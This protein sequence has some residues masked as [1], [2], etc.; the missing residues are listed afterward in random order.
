MYKDQALTIKSKSDI[1][2][3]RSRVRNLAREQGFNTM[4][5]AR[6]SLA[7][8][9]LANALGM[10]EKLQDQIIIGCLDGGA[11]STGL[12]V[13]CIKTGGAPDNGEPRAF[14]DVGLMVDEIT[15]EELPSNDLKVTVIKWQAKRR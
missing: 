14:G 15:V 12:R 9:S 6:I 8:S 2:F 7:T 3:A 13:I 1:I 4:D 11:R 5:Q 10:G